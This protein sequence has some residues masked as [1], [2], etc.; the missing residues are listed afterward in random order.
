MII[1]IQIRHVYSRAKKSDYINSRILK[2]KDEI[3]IQIRWNSATFP[4]EFVIM[5]CDFFYL[6]M[7]PCIKQQILN[8]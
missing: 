6:L 1:D 8:N 5:C 4:S 2:L 7:L 3:T